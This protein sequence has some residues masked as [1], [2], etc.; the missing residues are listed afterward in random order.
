MKTTKSE[1]QRISN[2][3]LLCS[4]KGSSR[5]SFPA[6]VQLEPLCGLFLNCCYLRS[7]HGQTVKSTK[8]ELQLQSALQRISNGDPLCLFDNGPCRRSFDAGLQYAQL[9]LYGPQVD[10]CAV[11]RPYA[12]GHLSKA[13][14]SQCRPGPKSGVSSWLRTFFTVDLFTRTHGVRVKLVSGMMTRRHCFADTPSNISTHTPHTTSKAN[15]PT[16]RS[17][18]VQL[19]FLFLMFIRW[20][21]SGFM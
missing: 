16:P 15:P 2:G 17:D 21:A 4:G 19:A 12:T 3:D 7:N 1:L 5:R 9:A 8:S 18:H 13:S 11:F 14:H 6:T 10:R 20:C